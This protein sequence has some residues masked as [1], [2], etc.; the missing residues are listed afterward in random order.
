MKFFLRKNDENKYFM[1]IS[2]NIVG[3]LYFQV[4]ENI[5]KFFIFYNKKNVLSIGFL[6]IEENIN[7]YEIKLN[8]LDNIKLVFKSNINVE[9]LKKN[10]KLIINLIEEASFEYIDNKNNN[11]Y[12]NNQ[13]NQNNQDNNNQDNQTNLTNLTNNEK[14]T[15]IDF[16]NKDLV[17]KEN[18]KSSN[19]LLD[20]ILQNIFNKKNDL[21]PKINFKF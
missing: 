3:Y 7:N 9:N 16:I 1:L 10:P 20:Y 8:N 14:N 15:K 18:N 19:L 17:N 21:L 12:N 11:Q 13:T 5:I 2:N 4:F 6:K